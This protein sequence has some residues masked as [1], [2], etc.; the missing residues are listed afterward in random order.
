MCCQGV[1][2]Q[3]DLHGQE[4]IV[5]VNQDQQEEY[6]AADSVDIFRNAFEELPLSEQEKGTIEKIVHSLANHN[7]PKLLW[8]Q[9]ELEK[10][11]KSINQVH[12]LRFIAHIISNPILRSDL[13]EIHR[14]FFKWRGFLDGFRRR[15][16]EEFYKNNLKPYL[17]GFC[18]ELHVK[19]EVV[20]HFMD[21]RDWEG[22]VKAILY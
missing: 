11:G 18:E 10:M 15:M 19:P 21:H 2:S 13:Q 5:M 3:V 7:V 16:T 17:T 1:V 22:L 20:E 4:Q 6:T 9:K 14:S 8:K 12:P